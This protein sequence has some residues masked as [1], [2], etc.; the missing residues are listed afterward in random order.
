MLHFAVGIFPPSRFDFKMCTECDN[1]DK[2]SELSRGVEKRGVEK[3]RRTKKWRG[4]QQ[5]DKNSKRKLSKLEK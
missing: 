3:D 4:K 5:L 1:A 2:A